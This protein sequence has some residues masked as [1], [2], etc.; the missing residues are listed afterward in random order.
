MHRES[1]IN[2]LKKFEMPL[3]LLTKKVIRKIRMDEGGVSLS[4]YILKMSGRSC[5]FFTQLFNIYRIWQ[6]FLGNL[7]LIKEIKPP[8]YPPVGFKKGEANIGLLAY[9]DR[10]EK[11]MKNV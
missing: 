3:K 7:A 10:L 8:K 11:L 1:L 2:I 9:M 5:N 4:G 6:I